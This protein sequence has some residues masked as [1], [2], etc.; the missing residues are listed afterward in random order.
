MMM[1]RRNKTELS[2]MT[3]AWLLPIVTTVVAAATG[4]NVADVL[5]NPYHA[6][7]VIIVS[8]VLWGIGVP[9]AMMVLVIYFQRLALHKLPPREVIVSM[10]LPMG[11]LGQGG[12]GMP[13][14]FFDVLGTILS[15]CVILLWIVVTVFTIRGIIAGEMIHAPCLKDI[16][17][18]KPQDEEKV[19]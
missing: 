2:E 8:Y 4:S 17:T 19:A 12:Y 13:S 5:D 11:P 1:T 15:V 10:F 9:L 16:K 3:A 7:W 6:L 18:A 14:A